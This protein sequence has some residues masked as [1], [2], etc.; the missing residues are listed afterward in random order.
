MLFIVCKQERASPSSLMSN[1]D[2]LSN[3]VFPLMVNPEQANQQKKGQGATN[4][5]EH[6]SQEKYH[7]DISETNFDEKG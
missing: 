6:V 4:V 2:C 7:N 5:P 3:L 1:R